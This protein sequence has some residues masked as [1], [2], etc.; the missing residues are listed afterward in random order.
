MV[1]SRKEIPMEIRLKCVTVWGKG[2]A[3]PH[4]RMRSPFHPDGWTW[5]RRGA[6]RRVPARFAE[7]EKGE[8]GEGQIRATPN[9][10][11]STPGRTR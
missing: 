5:S 3:P 2:R 10:H 4:L 9:W 7:R 6:H 1:E 11:R 8:I